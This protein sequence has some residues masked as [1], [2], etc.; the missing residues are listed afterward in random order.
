MGVTERQRTL[1]MLRAVGACR[2]AGRR[3]WCVI[4]GAACSR[5]SGVVDRRAAGLA[6]GEVP[7]WTF[8]DVFTRRRRAR[9]GAGSLFGVARLARCGAARRASCRRGSRCASARWRRC[10]RWPRRRARTPCV[11]ALCGLAADLRS[12]RSCS[13]ARSI[14]S[15]RC[16]GRTTRKCARQCSSTATSRSACR[17]LMIGFFLLAPLFVL[18]RR[19]A[20]SARSSRRCSACSSRCCGSSSP[21]A[22]GGR[23]GRAAAPDGRP[24]DA[25]RHADAGP[26][27]ARRLEAADKFPDIFIVSGT[28][29]RA[30]HSSEQDKLASVP[31]IGKGEVMPIAHR[32]AGVWH[33]GSSRS[34]ARLSCPTRRCSSASIR[35][36]ASR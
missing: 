22:S 16:F 35:H 2:G 18:D 17:V 19:A 8:A 12:T 11:A 15:S 5:L 31:G 23:R 10:R 33:A 20:C 14:R 1:A 24:G 36:G 4:E 27:D 13:S 29:R 9:A 28:S 6:L 30:R 3:G 26:L 21:A 7:A 25:R 34:P 32:V